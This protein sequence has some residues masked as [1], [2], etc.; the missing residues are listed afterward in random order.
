MN[1]YTNKILISLSYVANSYTSYKICTC[2][3]L[4][5]VYL[6]SNH[7]I[8]VDWICVCDLGV[9]HRSIV[10]PLVR[11]ILTIIKDIPTSYIPGRVMGERKQTVINRIKNRNQYQSDKKNI[12]IQNSLNNTIESPPIVGTVSPD[13]TY[14]KEILISRMYEVL[15]DPVSYRTLDTPRLLCCGHI[16]SEKSLT[17]DQKCSLC[18][19]VW[20]HC[21]ASPLIDSICRVYWGLVLYI[22]NMTMIRGN[23]YNIELEKPSMVSKEDLVSCNILQAQFEPCD[24]I[25]SARIKLRILFIKFFFSFYFRFVCWVFGGFVKRM[26]SNKVNTTTDYDIDIMFV[27]DVNRACFLSILK[28]QFECQVC[29]PPDIVG[30]DIERY[31][32]SLREQLIGPVI[33]LCLDLVVKPTLLFPICN[34]DVNSLTISNIGNIGCILPLHYIPSSLPVWMVGF[35]QPETIT[36]LRTQPIISNIQRKVCNLVYT[37]PITLSISYEGLPQKDKVNIDNTLPPHEQTTQL[38][39]HQSTL[40][41]KYLLKL[42]SGLETVLLSGWDVL[43]IFLE[44]CI[45]TEPSTDTKKVILK[46][47]CGHE[48]GIANASVYYD[49]TADGICIECPVCDVSSIVCIKNSETH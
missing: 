29:T 18:R 3:K 38:E 30:I 11:D 14:F 42:F 28:K 12:C 5:P 13:I 31:R 21:S 7:D 32:I 23:V 35:L 15:R 39:N 26:F 34:F 33:W 48:S 46:L 22:Q 6:I 44:V 20:N 17:S 24:I 27:T 49:H 19:Q 16:L 40:Y 45:I 36:T 1:N 9:D 37:E 25:A 4:W 2:G 41:D 10:V 43:N 47:V 8:P